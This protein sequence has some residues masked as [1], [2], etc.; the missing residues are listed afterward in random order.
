MLNRSVIQRMKPGHMVSHYLTSAYCYYWLDL[1]PM[2]D[3]AFDLLSRQLLAIYDTLEHQHKKFITRGD[4][5]AG[6]LGLPEKDY[7]TIIRG[8]GLDAIRTDLAKGL[9]PSFAKSG[10]SMCP[11]G[12]Y[13]DK[14]ISGQMLK[15]LEPHLHPVGY[16][17][18]VPTS[19]QLSQ[20]RLFDD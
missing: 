20:A 1:S 7:P 11:A 8:V 16:I 14:C 12:D 2:T 18:P 9:I 5:V 17:A 15:D 13:Y 4:L 19:E 10:V 3:D 6:T